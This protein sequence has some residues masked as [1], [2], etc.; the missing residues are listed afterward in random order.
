[1]TFEFF[2]ISRTNLTSVEYLKRHF[3]NHPAYFSG[4][5]HLKIDRPAVLGAEINTLLTALA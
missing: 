5:A 3:L 1:M 2:R 4:T